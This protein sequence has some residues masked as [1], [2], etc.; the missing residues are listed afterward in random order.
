MRFIC[1]AVAIKWKLFRN[2]DESFVITGAEVFVLRVLR[3]TRQDL[4]S[5]IVK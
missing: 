5:I 1:K 3:S 2:Y 4:L